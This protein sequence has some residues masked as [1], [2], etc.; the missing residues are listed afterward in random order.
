MQE[1]ELGVVSHY[2]GKVEVGI[3]E[4]SDS[5]KVGETIHVRGAHDDFTQK[6]D[7]MQIEHANVNEA[8]KGDSVGVKVPQRVHPNDKVYKV[9]EG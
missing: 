7:S 5:L 2:F 8:K 4:L 3:I 1:K 9:I 6:V